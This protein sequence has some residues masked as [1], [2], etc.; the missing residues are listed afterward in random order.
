MQYFQDVKTIRMIPMQ[1]GLLNTAAGESASAG[2]YGSGGGT[3]GRGIVDTAGADF[4]IIRVYRSKGN[5]AKCHAKIGHQSGAAAKYSATC[6]TS[7]I[8]SAIACLTTSNQC[9]KYIINLRGAAYKRY[10]NAKAFACANSAEVQV[11][12]DLVFLDSFP[13]SFNGFTTTRYLPA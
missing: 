11:D 4:A 1:H 2:S 9:H 8:A 7:T 10:L 5:S 6:G 13:P 12:C 3:S